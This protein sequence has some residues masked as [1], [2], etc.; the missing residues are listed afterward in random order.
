MGSP[1][2]KHAKRAGEDGY[3]QN[4]KFKIQFRG[5]EGLDSGPWIEARAVRNDG[6]SLARSHRGH[7]GKT[8]MRSVKRERE[9]NHRS[10]LDGPNSL[11]LT[12]PSS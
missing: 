5:D 7:R 9:T 3:V 6:E 12:K 1:L 10:C 11:W 4:A 2:A 8:F